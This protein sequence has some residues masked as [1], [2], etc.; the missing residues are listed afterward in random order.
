MAPAVPQPLL[1]LHSTS[2]IIDGSVVVDRVSLTVG[3][4]GI[5]T[6][7]RTDR[8]RKEHRIETPRRACSTDFGRSYR[9]RRPCRSFQRNGT[10]VAAS[11][12]GAHDAGR[13][14]A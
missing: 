14:A 11:L 13:T 6:A 9:C 7:P 8:K 3:R 12:Y 2:V 1:E 10:P 5:R 4:G